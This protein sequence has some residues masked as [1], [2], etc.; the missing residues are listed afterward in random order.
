[1]SSL[2]E[3]LR[4]AFVPFWLCLLVLAAAAAA[5]SGPAHAAGARPEGERPVGPTPVD[6]APRRPARVQ[7]VARRE[8]TIA[9]VVAPV[10]ARSAPHRRAPAVWSVPTATG[11]SGQAQALL[12]LRSAHDKS[13]RRWIKLELPIRPTE[14]TGWIPADYA[15]LSRS[16]YWIDVS[17]G[18]RLV[19]VYRAGRLVRRF[20]AVVG[21]P[22]TPTPHGLFALW[23]KNPQPDPHGFL[24]PW[25]L[26]ITAL[27]T[28]LESY[29]GGP[30]R[31]AIHGRDG[32]SLLTP[33]GTAASHGCIRVENVHVTW[34]AA[35]VPRGTP[36]RVGE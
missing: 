2:R 9:R 34:L 14:R 12:V 29:G 30:G 18:R 19:S 36:V 25:S 24:G 11:W 8:A 15:T 21:A 10:V 16:G 22:G 32:T 1:M 6:E 31:V 13:G 33:L 35:R 23:E 17:T 26:P 27:S 28:V 7:P 4:Q 3:P 5:S 20:G